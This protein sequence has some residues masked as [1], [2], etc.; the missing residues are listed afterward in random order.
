MKI[1]IFI[2]RFDECRPVFV[3]RQ[4]LWE[5]CK[6]DKSNPGSFVVYRRF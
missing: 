3:P 6:G 4:A 1:D 5:L 2:I